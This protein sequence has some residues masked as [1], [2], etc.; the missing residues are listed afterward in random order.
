LN[1]YGT[2]LAKDDKLGDLT[3][4]LIGYCPRSSLPKLFE[5]VGRMMIAGES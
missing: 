5:A 3:A 1:G 4:Q 2:E